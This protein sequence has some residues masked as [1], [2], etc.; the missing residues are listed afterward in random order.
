MAVGNDGACYIP[1]FHQIF[2][3]DQVG[4]LGRYTY[5]RTPLLIDYPLFDG[6]NSEKL[7]FAAAY[8]NP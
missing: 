5:P 8:V 3:P 7:T 1:K 6:F 4:L 2:G